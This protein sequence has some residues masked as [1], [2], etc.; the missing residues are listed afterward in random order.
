MPAPKRIVIT[1][2]SRGLGRALVDGF[3]PGRQQE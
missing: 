2:V 3:I 1:G